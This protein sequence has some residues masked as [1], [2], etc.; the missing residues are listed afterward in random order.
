MMIGS[1][2][3]EELRQAHETLLKD[4]QGLEWMAQGPGAVSAADL[5]RRLL[6][7][8]KDVADHFHLEEQEVYPSPVL[9]MEPTWDRK[10]RDLMAE[11]Q[12]LLQNLDDLIENG[13]RDTSAFWPGIRRWI[14]R[15]RHH[16]ARETEFFDQAGEDDPCCGRE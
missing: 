16:E 8:R 15:L 13:P 2:P 11:H 3:L 6:A 10:A 4:L 14:E 1:N 9:K 5:R 12:T 7:V